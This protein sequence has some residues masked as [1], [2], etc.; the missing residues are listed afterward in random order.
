[1]IPGDTNA[2]SDAYCLDRHSGELS[3]VSVNSAEALANSN[4]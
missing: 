1:L 2:A 4:S 3:L